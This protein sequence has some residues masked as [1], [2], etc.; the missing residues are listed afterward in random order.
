MIHLFYYHKNGGKK[1]KQLKFE[2]IKEK[3]SCD[4]CIIIVYL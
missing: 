1:K 3:A 2:C 4:L